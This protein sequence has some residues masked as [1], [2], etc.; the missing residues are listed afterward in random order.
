MPRKRRSKQS[1]LQSAYDKRWRL[2]ITAPVQG[3]DAVEEV[4]PAESHTNSNH[5][6]DDDVDVADEF[7]QDQTHTNN[8][9]VEE[10]QP[11]QSHT[12]KNHVSQDNGIVTDEPHP[13]QTQTQNNPL[14]DNIPSLCESIDR[15]K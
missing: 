11:V 2:P 1:A 9:P 8:N 15:K 7:E 13:T 12:E 14:H 3:I 10:V 4:H 5:G 6:C